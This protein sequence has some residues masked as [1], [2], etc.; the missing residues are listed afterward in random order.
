MNSNDKKSYL[1]LQLQFQLFDSNKRKIADGIDAKLPAQ[2]ISNLVLFNLKI[3]LMKCHVRT[4]NSPV[5]KKIK[6]R[7]ILNR[8]SHNI[9]AEYD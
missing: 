2:L 5:Q 3:P 4:N 1:S 7:N 9:C 6:H 8:K